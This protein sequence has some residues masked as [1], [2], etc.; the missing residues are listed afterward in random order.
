MRRA[1]RAGKSCASQNFFYI[2]VA[3]CKWKWHENLHLRREIVWCCVQ[4]SGAEI[5]AAI[6]NFVVYNSYFIL[7]PLTMCNL[8][9]YQIYPQMVNLPLHDSR[10]AKCK[11]FRRVIKPSFRLQW[12]NYC[13]LNYS[14]TK[15]WVLCHFTTIWLG[16][17]RL[18][19]KVPHQK[20]C[21]SFGK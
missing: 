5:I 4:V 10:S 8:N 15:D 9:R 3:D 16:Y 20:P 11:S 12:P 1:K 6:S 17:F 7:L 2:F 21:F 19:Q 18:S 14:N 13:Q